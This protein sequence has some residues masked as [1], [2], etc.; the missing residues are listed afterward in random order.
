MLAL[1]ELRLPPPNDDML[2]T[3]GREALYQAL[4][5]LRVPISRRLGVPPARAD[6][7]AFL[8]P[9]N[10]LIIHGWE[11]EHV[12]K[13]CDHDAEKL[14]AREWRNKVVPEI[15]PTMTKEQIAEKLDEAAGNITVKQCSILFNLISKFEKDEEIKRCGRIQVQRVKKGQGR[16]IRMVGLR[17]MGKGWSSA[18]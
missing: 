6:L 11:K 8:L 15:T 12:V 3:R 14:S 18:R 9:T 16:E 10:T 13:W 17:P 4:H 5:P 2:I 1:D 7:H